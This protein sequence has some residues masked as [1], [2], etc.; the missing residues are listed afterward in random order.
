MPQA[1][2]WGPAPSFCAYREKSRLSLSIFP[3]SVPLTHHRRESHARLTAWNPLHPRLG[4]GFCARA[5]RAAEGAWRRARHP[6]RAAEGCISRHQPS[7]KRWGALCRRWRARREAAK[8]GWKCMPQRLERG[9]LEKLTSE[10]SNAH[11]HPPT[12]THLSKPVGCEPPL[13]PPHRALSL[14]AAGASKSAPF[15]TLRP[16]LRLL[17]N[18]P[19]PHPHLHHAQHARLGTLQQPFRRKRWLPRQAP[20]RLR[21]R[22]ETAASAA[23]DS[24]GL[25]LGV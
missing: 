5:A 16:V 14:T 23:Q 17:S 19:P 20:S 7:E 8:G 10:H 6:R 4:C 21:G 13:H 3:P 25:G 1:S 15:P 11:P 12:P 18:P 22:F 9:M 2:T 24:S